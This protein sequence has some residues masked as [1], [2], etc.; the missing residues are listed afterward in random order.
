MQVE[1]VGQSP[2]PC[3]PSDTWE[4][5][6]WMVISTENVAVSAVPPHTACEWSHQVLT[7]LRPERIVRV[8]LGQHVDQLRGAFLGE[9]FD[10]WVVNGHDGGYPGQVVG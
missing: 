5:L 6:G 7:Q 4:S 1:S 3:W 2:V 10:G 8:C 9:G